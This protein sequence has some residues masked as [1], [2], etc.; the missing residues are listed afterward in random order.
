MDSTA[1]PTARPQEA[2]TLM[3]VSA[4]ALPRYL[5]QFK[6]RANKIPKRIMD[7]V[8]SVMP[9]ITPRA[10]PVMAEWPRAS[11]K[12][13]I[14]LFTII[15]PSSPNRGVISSTAASA[16]FINSYSNM[17][18]PPLF[19]SGVRTALPPTGQTADAPRI[20]MSSERL[21][22]GTPAPAFPPPPRFYQA[23]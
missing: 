11:E 13:A 9:S 5:I 20:R 8:V 4:P 17:V 21:R 19:Q 23:K 2:N 10:I 18:I 1:S 14:L 6:S 15:V 22:S 7:R 16:F 12:N 3:T